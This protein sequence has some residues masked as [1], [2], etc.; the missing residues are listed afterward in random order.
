LF[1]H[2]ARIS[3]LSWRRLVEAHPSHC[4][5]FRQKYIFQLSAFLVV[6]LGFMF[7]I[8]SSAEQMSFLGH[9]RDS[10]AF[11]IGRL[12]VSNAA[13]FY[14]TGGFLCRSNNETIDDA[15]ETTYRL[16][17]NDQSIEPTECPPYTGQVGLQGQLL[18]TVDRVLR[19]ADVGGSTRFTLLHVLVAS[20][21]AAIIAHLCWLFR[22]EF[23]LTAA[24]A[25]VAI[26]IFSPWLT[27]F[28]RNLYWVPFTWFLPMVVAWHAYVRSPPPVGK[29]TYLAG[30]A[31]G[32]AVLMKCLCGFEYISETVGAAASVAAYGLIRSGRGPRDLLVQAVVIGS[33]A[34]AA[35]VIGLVLQLTMLAAYYGSVGAAWGNFAARVAIN[36]HDSSAAYTG[37]VAESLQASVFDVLHTYWTG[38]SVINIGPWYSANAADILIPVGSFVAIAGGVLLRY[39]WYNLQARRQIL[40]LLAL[41]GGAAISALS[42]YILAKGHSF[43]HTHMNYVLWHLPL[44]IFLAPICVVLLWRLASEP[45]LRI[46][47]VG[48]AVVLVSAIIPALGRSEVPTFATISTERGIVAFSN[49]GLLFDFDCSDIVPNKRFFVHV[50]SKPRF[51]PP[52]SDNLDFL[53]LDF[54]WTNA[55]LDN[56]I[57]RHWTGHCRAFTPFRSGK[58]TS[59]P[60]TF[61]RFGQYRS[62]TD[63]RRIWQVDIKSDRLSSSPPRALPLADFTDYQWTNGIHKTRSGFFV[64]NTFEN[65]QIVAVAAGVEIAGRRFPFE[66]ITFGP[67]WITFFF[68][69]PGPLQIGSVRAIATY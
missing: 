58:M 61:L 62:R 49:D 45:V 26:V 64:G 10:E 2:K 39:N 35:V 12:I 65:R 18:A 68:E 59:I 11:V 5:C 44:L 17:L 20:M 31:I 46:S 29:R 47:L 3:V 69:R 19:A 13:G 55:R 22:L 38:S 33:A 23:G 60:V 7:N 1:S 30:A 57:V 25:A 9:Q 56:P 27:V 15:V 34:V 50:G 53:N 21:G 37:E 43:I 6:F 48:G 67:E 28:G 14:S 24:I 16:F 4:I 42:W 51:L 54:D 8:F 41:A 63:Q 52:S 36:T 32:L 40:A 66:E